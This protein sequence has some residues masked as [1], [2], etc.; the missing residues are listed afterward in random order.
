MSL[1]IKISENDK[2][3]LRLWKVCSPR[4]SS[5]RD[6]IWAVTTGNC[7]PTVTD[8][9]HLTGRSRHSHSSTKSSPPPSHTQTLIFQ[10]SLI[11]SQ[12]WFLFL[13]NYVWHVFWGLGA[14]QL[15]MSY[16]RSLDWIMIT[17]IHGSGQR[18]N[19]QWPGFQFNI[20]FPF[21]KWNTRVDIF[22]WSPWTYG[23]NDTFNILIKGTDLV[24][25][26]EHL[27]KIFPPC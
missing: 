6:V 27:N 20:F 18:S 17:E 4:S 22:L 15:S 12:F 1:Y 14:G 11:S 25:L 24:A 2:S 8:Q 26:L 16:N 10:I 7:E 13:L 23:N 5:G 21:W 19:S 3:W 9:Q